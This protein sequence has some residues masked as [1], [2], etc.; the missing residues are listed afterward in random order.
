MIVKTSDIRGAG[1][2][3][4]VFIQL[5]GEKNDSGKIPLETSKNNKNKFERG[6]EDIF[7]VKE[8]DIGDLRKVRVGHDGKGPGAG[9]HL[10]EI[11]VDAPKLGK[12]WR[13]PCDRWFDKGEDDGKIE[14][15]L[16]PMDVSFEEY[17]PCKSYFFR[18]YN[19]KLF[20]IF[21]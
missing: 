15:E 3:A 11:I 9:W 5:F 2:D 12:K 8:A 7:E 4:N 14:R 17:N 18:I 16:Y 6:N 21:M 20:K 19:L 10:K 1:T 13:F